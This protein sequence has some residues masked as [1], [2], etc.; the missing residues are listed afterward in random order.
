[1]QILHADQVNQFTTGIWGAQVHLKGIAAGGAGVAKAVG[2]GDAERGGRA[3][4]R[5]GE[6]LGGDA[7]VGGVHG[8]G[9]NCK[10]RNGAQ[11]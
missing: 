11:V 8:A 2:R 3:G 4:R 1:M 6:A 9:P 10:G 7:A 5:A